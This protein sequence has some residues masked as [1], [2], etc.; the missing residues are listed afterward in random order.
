M[1]KHQPPGHG[2]RSLV[3]PQPLPQL[4]QQSMPQVGLFQDQAAQQYADD[5]PQ[6]LYNTAAP[7]QGQLSE[8]Q[9]SQLSMVQSA[10]K[11][12]GA[13]LAL[14]NAFKRDTEPPQVNQS[15]QNPPTAGHVTQQDT[16]Q[17]SSYLQHNVPGV[18]LSQLDSIATRRPTV[19]ANVSE[20]VGSS[21]QP[22]ED[23]HRS[24]LLDMFK[25]QGATDTTISPPQSGFVQGNPLGGASQ[26]A[27]QSGQAANTILQQLQ[28]SHGLASQQLSLEKLFVQSKPSQSAV[29]SP[30][31]KNAS[32]SLYHQ[33]HRS[34]RQQQQQQQ[35]QPLVR[36]PFAS[37]HGHQ[38][39]PPRILQRG[40][41]LDDFTNPAAHQRGA[42]PKAS[43]ATLH[44]TRQAFNGPVPDR[45]LSAIARDQTRRPDGAREQKQQ[46]LSLFGKQ[47][48]QG[49]AEPVSAM[50]SEDGA[51]PPRS[52]V[53]SMASR[54]GDTPISPAEQIFLLDYLQSV[55]NNVGR[56]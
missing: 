29:V 39:Q 21:V 38:P 27:G 28:Q 11:L 45:P 41:T 35:Q 55:T 8:Q 9:S 7:G 6:P 54:G 12:S 33:H 47:Q 4:A 37:S 26:H 2:H 10:A 40:Q 16:P 18:S 52:R 14:L 51:E 43:P 32:P 3:H 24:A 13:S 53:S 20:L 42:S 56:R 5:M 30:R 46:L 23:P 50:E 34:P 44:S 25:K 1:V 31:E 36:S 22:K 49:A 17:G 48:S 15:V 19:Q